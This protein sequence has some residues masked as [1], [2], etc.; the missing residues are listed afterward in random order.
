MSIRL[1]TAGIKLGYA[2][3]ATAGTRPTGLKD[4]GSALGFLMNLTQDSKTA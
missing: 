3:E 1:S 4:M 2:V